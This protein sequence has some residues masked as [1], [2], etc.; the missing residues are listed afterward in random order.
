MMMVVEEERLLLSV[1]PQ[2]VAETMR[3]DLGRGGDGQFK[4][5]YM[6][7]HENHIMSRA[8]EEGTTLISVHSGSCHLNHSTADHVRH[9]PHA[10]HPQ[11]PLGY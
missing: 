1:L 8:D 6:S 7:R 3:Q 5:I 9:T 11:A 2:H 4:K 10:S